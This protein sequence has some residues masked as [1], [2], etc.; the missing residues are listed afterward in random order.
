MQLNSEA[1]GNS[2]YHNKDEKAAQKAKTPNS[3]MTGEKPFLDGH[4]SIFL[5]YFAVCA[6]LDSG[7]R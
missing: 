2:C 6:L 4:L 3:T 1:Y 7:A 5:I